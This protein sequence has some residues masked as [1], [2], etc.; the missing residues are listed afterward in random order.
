M[1][2]TFVA[3]KEVKIPPRPVASDEKDNCKQTS[4]Q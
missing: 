1:Q 3:R 2:K 4:R